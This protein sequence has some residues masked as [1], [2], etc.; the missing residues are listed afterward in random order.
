MFIVSFK[1]NRRKILVTVLIV[2][3]GIL[4]A[5]S[6]FV[7]AKDV[8]IFNTLQKEEFAFYFTGIKTNT[9]RVEFLKQFGWVVQE[10]TIEIIEIQIP[11]EFDQVY[12]NYNAI[13]KEIGLDLTKYRGKRV[14][15]YTYKVLNYPIE[16]QGEVRANLLVYKNRVIA[17]DIMTTYMQGFMHSL[18]YKVKDGA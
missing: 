6:M 3:L 16:V 12:A 11:E 13:Q 1:L 15:R 14:K 4:L 10:D 5:V 8:K 17:G 9:D 7:K 2:L 18:L